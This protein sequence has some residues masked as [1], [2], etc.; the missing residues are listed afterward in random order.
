MALFSIDICVDISKNI[1]VYNKFYPLDRTVGVNG[2]TQDP[3]V[4]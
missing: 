2:K 4:T 1:Y 3:Q